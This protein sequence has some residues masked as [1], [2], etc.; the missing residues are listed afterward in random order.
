MPTFKIDLSK[1]TFARL[2]EMAF[3]ERR[4]IPLQI[5]VLVMRALGLWGDHGVTGAVTQDGLAEA[6][7]R[8][9]AAHDR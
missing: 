3:Q 4:P 8:H 2:A 5:E 1:D 7:E 9:G 6:G